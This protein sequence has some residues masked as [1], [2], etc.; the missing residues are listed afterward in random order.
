[1][2]SI[3]CLDISADDKFVAT[4]DM[5]GLVIVRE[6]ATGRV[7]ASF[8]ADH[9]MCGL[10]CVRFSPDGLT[11]DGSF[12]RHRLG[13]GHFQTSSLIDATACVPNVCRTKR[14]FDQELWVALR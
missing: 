1:M 9:R 11:V 5:Q 12:R 7:Y 2:K 3:T 6:I 14:S 10:R 13:V 8:K 4:G